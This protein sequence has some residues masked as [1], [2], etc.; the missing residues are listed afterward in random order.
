MS[1]PPRDGP[2]PPPLRSRSEEPRARRLSD[3]GSSA[4]AP[5]A[6][7]PASGPQ[8]TLT[9]R[10]ERAPAPGTD[11]GRP[12]AEPLYQTAV[13]DF[14]SIAAS[15]PAFEGN[16]YVYTRNGRPNAASLEQSIAKLEGAEAA[17]A[18][19]SGMTAVLCALWAATKPGER[20]LCQRDV[21]GGTRALL[22]ADAPRL[23]L[24][25]EYIDAYEP[26]KVADGLARGARF[27]L[28]E[29]LSNPLLREVD[30]GALAWHTRAA[31][32]VLCV[33]NTMATP[34]F[35]RPLEQGADLVLHSVTKFLGG[36][37]DLCAGA[38]AGRRTLIDAARA[39]SVRMGLSAAPLDAWLAQRGLRTLSV[40]M[41]RAQATAR[42][43]APRLNEHAAVRQVH[44]PG[45]GALLS[46]DLG[47]RAAAER[48]V[49]RCT[50]I[51]LTPSLGGTETA[52][53]H[54]ASSSH[55]ALSAEERARLGIGEG[56]LR[57][58]VGLEEASDLWDEL[59]QA[60]SS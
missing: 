33:D 9:A 12:S 49:T 34:V 29:T 40:R 3:F 41:Q 44:Y 15:E 43:L 19:A 30:I 54:S 8:A 47:D 38:L 53:S 6:S 24:T 16:G 46:L 20:V 42:T 52:L 58:S 39:A 1:L 45:W 11:V 25:V 10:G 2:P 36:H 32:A 5:R 51:R 14:P 23:G 55:R 7:T 57:M 22:D 35:R 60:L 4:E 50:Q 13:F 31:S 48:L 18:T 27:L 28:V 59:A 56:L 17:L 37:H 21:Y 26:A